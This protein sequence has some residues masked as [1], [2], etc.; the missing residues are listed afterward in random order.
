M[1]TLALRQKQ[2][3]FVDVMEDKKAAAMYDLL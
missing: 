3:Q 2:H 1:T